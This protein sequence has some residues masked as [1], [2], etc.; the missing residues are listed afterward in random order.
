VNIYVET[1][2]V[3]ELTFQQEQSASCEQILRYCEA[4]NGKLVIPAYSLAEPHEKLRRQ[5]T[6]RKEIQQALNAE[7]HQ[8]SRTTPYKGRISNIQDIALLYHVREHT[9]SKMSKYAFGRKHAL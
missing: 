7:L 3:L 1:N 5:A 8:L 6:S 2:F 9:H 4:G